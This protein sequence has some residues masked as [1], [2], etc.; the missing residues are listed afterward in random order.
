MKY[1]SMDVAGLAERLN[2]ARKAAHVTQ[3]AAANHLNM[4]RPT[5][6]A[7][8]KPVRRPK[9]VDCRAPQAVTAI[10][11]F[12]CCAGLRRVRGIARFPGAALLR[13]A[14]FKLPAFAGERYRAWNGTRSS[15]VLA[16][17]AAGQPDSRRRI[18]QGKPMAILPAAEIDI[19][20]LSALLQRHFQQAAGV[21]RCPA[22]PLHGPTEI[23]HCGA[24][25]FAPRFERCERLQP[26]R[27]IAQIDADG[28]AA[29]ISRHQHH[30][31]PDTDRLQ[32]IRV[33]R[34]HQSPPA[35]IVH[36]CPLA[37]DIFGIGLDPPLR[38]A[39]G[40]CR[41]P[42]IKRLAGQIHHRPAIR[43]Q[44][45]SVNRWMLVA[46]HRDDPAFTG[47]KLSHGAIVEQLFP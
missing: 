23:G 11:S 41:Y 39:Q 12:Q 31:G 5:Y 29:G 25:E 8:G 44:H 9:H 10:D 7:M 37:A 35:R 38:G 16:H 46:P 30:A 36:L 20:R 24:P 21:Q 13:A 47:M 32:P 2:A 19:G 3:E 26:P 22:G 43:M 34:F 17:R 15:A 40:L 14:L 6:I 27:Y 4:S 18:R 28:I 42:G 1:E 33:F 45:M